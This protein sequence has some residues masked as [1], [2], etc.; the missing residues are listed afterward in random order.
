MN[1]EATTRRD[2]MKARISPA[3]VIASIALFVSLSGTAVAAGIVVTGANV[4]NGSLTGIDVRDGSLG[5]NDIKD[6]SIGTV[7]VK[8]GSLLPIDFKPG[9]LPAGPQGEQGPAGPQGPAGLVGRPGPQG[10]K[11]VPGPK[12]AQGPKGPAGPKGDKGIQGPPGLSGIMVTRS[13]LTNSETFKYVTATCPEGKRPISGGYGVLGLPKE[14]VVQ[15]SYP[16]A[17]E[18]GW[19]VIAREVS[20]YAPN[21]GLAVYAVCATVG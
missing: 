13:I 5:P 15:G 19:Q 12:G 11:G 2:T 1:R 14:V 3:T 16:F 8:N 4:V 21:W 20:P 7:D 9:A 6:S 10:A 18:N 17:H